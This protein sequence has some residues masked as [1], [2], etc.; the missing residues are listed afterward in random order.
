MMYVT[1]V[2]DRYYL[3]ALSHHDMSNEYFLDDINIQ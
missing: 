1:Y 3:H 2:S